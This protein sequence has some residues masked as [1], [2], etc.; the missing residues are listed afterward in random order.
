[1]AAIIISH[2]KQMTFYLIP[3]NSM[4]PILF[5]LFLGSN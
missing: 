1:M 4:N 2:S 5:L 3:K